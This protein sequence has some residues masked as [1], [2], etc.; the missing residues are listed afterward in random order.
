MRDTSPEY[1]PSLK[2]QAENNTRAAEAE[3]TACGFEFPKV[4]YAL[5]IDSEKDASD[6]EYQ[7]QSFWIDFQTEQGRSKSGKIFLPKG[8]FDKL[9]CIYG[10]LPGDDIVKKEKLFSNA[11]LKDGYAVWVSRHNGT[12]LNEKNTELVKWYIK[13][14]LQ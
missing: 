3:L 14:D 9:V 4:N 13:Q 7:G 1:P 2:E 11:L 12:R 8:Q 6:E 10:G 5:K